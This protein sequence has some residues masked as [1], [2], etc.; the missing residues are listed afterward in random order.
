MITLGVGRTYRFFNNSAAV[1]A[2]GGTQDTYIRYRF[3]YGL[4]F[5][6][7][8][9]S[10]AMVSLGLNGSV[11]VEVDVAAIGNPAECRE[12]TQVYL[13]LPSLPGL[14]TPIF[15]LVAFT[16]TP[17]IP[18]QGATHLTLSVGRDDLLTT[19]ADGSRTF[20]GGKYTFFIGG[21]LPDDEKGSKQ[22]NVLV[23]SISM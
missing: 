19:A 2:S 21:H 6:S 11:T 5:C 7:F 12:V 20:T 4:S 10:N 14:V 8:A 3:G 15:S 1:T 23:A 16:V 22:S 9:Y 17:L 18:G 13:T